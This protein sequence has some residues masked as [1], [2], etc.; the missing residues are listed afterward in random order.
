MPE[1]S[2]GARILAA[3]KHPAWATLAT[4]V[5]VAAVVLALVGVKAFSGAADGDSAALKVAALTFGTPTDVDA[6][7]YGSGIPIEDATMIT[8]SATPIDITLKNSTDSPMRIVRIETSIL[9]AKTISCNP[10]GSGAMVSAFYSVKIPFEP[11]AN[12]LPSKTV[13]SDI[14]F[15]VKPSSVDRM[16][17]TVGPD[18]I[19]NGNPVVVSLSMKLIPESGDP[20]V[21][22]PL[23]LSQPD[24]VDQELRSM[25]RYASMQSAC[26]DKTV[27]VLDGFLV[28]TQ[29]HS[30]DV[31]RL[32]DAFRAA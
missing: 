1:D 16:V 8:N 32:S 31:T 23:A 24:G 4:L 3:V 30:P 29:I 9:D 22:A 20:V 17:I 19:G 15:T 6:K 13:T 27:G 14:D 5:S 21:I 11:F 2:T 10:Q 7:A 28:A 12:N 25:T 26:I 18:P